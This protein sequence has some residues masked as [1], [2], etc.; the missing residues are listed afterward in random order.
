M[1]SFDKKHKKGALCIT[2]IDLPVYILNYLLNNTNISQFIYIYKLY[3]L[4]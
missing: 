1:V 4:F 3:S 2:Q